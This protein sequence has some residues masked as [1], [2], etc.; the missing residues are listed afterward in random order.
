MDKSTRAHPYY[1]CQDG[2]DAQYGSPDASEFC[3]ACLLRLWL[4]Y[5]IGFTLSDAFGVVF[6]LPLL[7]LFLF[8]ALLGKD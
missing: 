4:V 7:K 1:P 5:A 3:L 6:A 2:T 8:G